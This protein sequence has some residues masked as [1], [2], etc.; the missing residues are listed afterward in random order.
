MF[1]DDI[2]ALVYAPFNDKSNFVGI[3]NN[4]FEVGILYHHQ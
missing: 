3:G 2:L 1:N 4:F